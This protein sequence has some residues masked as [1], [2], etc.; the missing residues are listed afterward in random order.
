MATNSIERVSSPSSSR[1]KFLCLVATLKAK[2]IKSLEQF[3]AAEDVPKDTPLNQLLIAIEE[4]KRLQTPRYEKALKRLVEAD[5]S[6]TPILPPETEW[7]EF[8]Q[9]RLGPMKRSRLNEYDTHFIWSPVEVWVRF[10]R[11]HQDKRAFH[12]ISLLTGESYYA[13]VNG[14][15]WISTLKMMEADNSESFPIQRAPNSQMGITLPALL[16]SKPLIPIT[17]LVAN[18]IHA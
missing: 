14:S 15:D 1:R 18:V 6:F 8:E 7:V 12:I 3:L 11:D 9:L 5:G 4:A 16:L 17:P 13:L 10:C 2:G